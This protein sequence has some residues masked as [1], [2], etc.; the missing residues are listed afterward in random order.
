MVQAAPGGRRAVR[1]APAPTPA[2]HP[3]RPTATDGT[4]APVQ[5][6]WWAAVVWGLAVAAL[7]TGVWVLALRTTAGAAW[8][9]VVGGTVVWL[10]VVF[11][12]FGALAPLLPASY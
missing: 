10:G 11:L 12:F 8:L 6:S 1:D 2:A 9:V 3:H 5:G 4:D 7:V